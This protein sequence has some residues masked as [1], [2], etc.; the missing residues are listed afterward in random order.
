MQTNHKLL[1]DMLNGYY[2]IITFYP[3]FFSTKALE[4]EFGF[5]FRFVFVYL[6][7]GINS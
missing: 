2:L 5:E 3:M 6:I 7:D 1:Y 4:F